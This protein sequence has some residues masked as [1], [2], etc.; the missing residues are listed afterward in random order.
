ATFDLPRVLDTLAESAARLCEADISAI[1]RQRGD[2]YYLAS[3]YGY[4]REIIEHVKTIPHER[5]RGSVVG[6][7]VLATNTVHVVDVLADPEYT[8]LEMQQLLGL[9]TV[10]AVPLLREG[11]PIGV[12]SLARK[13]VRPF[14]DRQIE[15]LKTF[16]DQAVI[17]IE[18]T[19]LFEAE[20][21]S[22]RELQESLKYQTA[23]SEVLS[24]ISRSQTEIRPVFDAILESA[25]RLCDADQGGTG[26]VENGML[27]AINWYPDTPEVAAVFRDNF[28]R[29]VDRTSHVGQAVIEKRVLHVPDVEAQNGTK[30]STPVSKRLVYRSQVSVPLL[31]TG[32]PIGVLALVRKAPDPFTPAQI[33]LATP[34]ADQAGIAIEN[35]RLFEEVQART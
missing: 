8:N 21:A 33:A 23:I 1:A 29:P 19:R 17:A 20:Q 4:P 10:L 35:T 11:V 16:A 9:R 12:I 34:F 25:V 32:H 13:S 14:A 28:P 7:T 30:L 6:R 26:K 31:Q 22:K 5:G 2:A 15:L 27:F 3:V 18:N 24:V